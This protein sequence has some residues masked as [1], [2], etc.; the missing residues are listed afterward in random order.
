MT[1][2]NSGDSTHLD[3][4]LIDQTSLKWSSLDNIGIYEYCSD[5]QSSKQK[6]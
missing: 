5:N 2:V 1:T 6:T 3:K 4:Q